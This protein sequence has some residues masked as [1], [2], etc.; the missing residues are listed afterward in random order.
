MDSGRWNKIEIKLWN[1]KV[2]KCSLKEWLFRIRKSNLQKSDVSK[3][4]EYTLHITRK[5]ESLKYPK[6][7]QII[8]KIEWDLQEGD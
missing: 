2:S 5:V 7:I 3:K 6:I 8:M 4:S 1:T